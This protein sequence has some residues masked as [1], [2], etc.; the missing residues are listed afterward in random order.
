MIN[1]GWYETLEEARL[2]F[3]EV[4]DKW[5]TWALPQGVHRRTPPSNAAIIT[6][7][8]WLSHS[9]SCAT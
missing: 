5:L 6:Q 9:V 1:A 8:S 3:C 2:Q 7:S 4:F